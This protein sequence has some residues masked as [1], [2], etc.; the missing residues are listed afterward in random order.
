MIPQQKDRPGAPEIEPSSD[1]Q[2]GPDERIRTFRPLLPEGSVLWHGSLR[3]T[4]CA[5]QPAVTTIWRELCS[6][7]PDTRAHTRQAGMRQAPSADD[8]GTYS[9]VAS[10]PRALRPHGDPLSSCVPYLRAAIVELRRPWVRSDRGCSRR[11]SDCSSLPCPVTLKE[12]K[13]TSRSLPPSDR[14]RT[15]TNI[16]TAGSDAPLARLSYSPNGVAS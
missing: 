15:E 8:S 3:S 4:I 9:G 1:F 10:A 6:R 11:N 7:S 14:C 12:P 13:R 16:K 5:G 2:I